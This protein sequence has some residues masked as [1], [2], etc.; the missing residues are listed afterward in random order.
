MTPAH[1][2]P[3]QIACIAGLTE[4]HVRRMIR[5][6]EG[7]GP[8]VS[9]DWFGVRMQVCRTDD[10]VQVAFPSLPDHIREAFVMLDQ[11]EL[12]LTPPRNM[13]FDNGKLEKRYVQFKRPAQQDQSPCGPC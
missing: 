1:V 6:A 2:T 3:D 7:C 5:R 12:P 10:A 9:R 8:Y 11:K 13:N 4:K